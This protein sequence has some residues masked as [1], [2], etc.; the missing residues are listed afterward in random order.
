MY[1]RG[2]KTDRSSLPRLAHSPKIDGLDLNFGLLIRLV[3]R[4]KIKNFAG[5]IYNGEELTHQ[6]VKR[7]GKKNYLKNG[8]RSR[9]EKKANGP[10]VSI[11]KK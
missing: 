1:I 4:V 9:L 2:C 8:P 7:I 5:G 10:I 6:P 11:K 3:H